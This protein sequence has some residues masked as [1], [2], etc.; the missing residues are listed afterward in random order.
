MK[1]IQQI[2][3][4]AT[5]WAKIAHSCLLEDEKDSFFWASQHAL[6]FEKEAAEELRSH[7]DAEPTRSVLFRS[8]ASLAYNIGEFDQSLSWIEAALSGKPFTELKNELLQ[9][10]EKGETAISNGYDFDTVYA[11]LRHELPEEEQV[12]ERKYNFDDNAETV[13]AEDDVK[14]WAGMEYETEEDRKLLDQLNNKDLAAY[15]SF[16]EKYREDMFRYV[17]R[18][19]DPKDVPTIVAEIFGS[20]YSKENSSFRSIRDV[21][22]SLYASARLLCLRHLRNS[23]GF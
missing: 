23:Q 6:L 13:V 4:D 15:F 17:N 20:F 1:N 7:P 8:A 9:L 18:L 2:H 10:K 11:I 3:R 14:Y 5:K 22:A 16:Y 19:A 21:L 12:S